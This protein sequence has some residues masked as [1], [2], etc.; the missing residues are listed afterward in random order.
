MSKEDQ[1]EVSSTSS[2]HGVRLLCLG[3]S[4]AFNSGGRS[5]SC[6]W[7]D[8]A[9]GTYL[10]DCGPTTTQALKREAHQ[11]SLHTLDVIYLTHLH[12][13]HINGI[14][15]LLLELNFGQQRQRPL[16]IIGP[17]TT[18]ARVETLCE[19]SYPTM[20]SDL[21]SFD[22]CFQEH[23]LNA[24]GQQ[25]GRQL[26][27][28]GAH[29]DP[30]AYPTSLRLTDSQGVSLVFSGDTGWN[31]EFINLSADADAFIL[32]CSYAKPFFSGHISLEEIINMRAKL[33]PT[34]LILTHL[35]VASRAAALSHQE[36]FRF[37]V[38]DDG[39]QWLITHT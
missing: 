1:M 37:E 8:D 9:D 31:E 24:E 10:I 16:W 29:H 22:I 30:A 28:I 11:V 35:G 23:P 36:K 20:L 25:G 2:E 13:D 21:I 19:V 3:S 32:E 38:A 12:G 6:Y 17:P 15:V 4:D 14:P 26:K 18:Q 39:A 5:N 34:R 27:S 7:V 33:T